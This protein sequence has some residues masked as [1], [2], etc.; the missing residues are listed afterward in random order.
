VS[1][2][3]QAGAFAVGAAASGALLVG[4]L[5]ALAARPGARTNAVVMALGAGVLL[6]SVSYDL[7]EEADSQL[8]FWQVAVML[9][10]GSAVFLIGARW[11]DRS[12]GHR[13][14]HPEGHDE[15]SQGPAIVL[16]SVLDGIPESVVLGLSI[17]QGAISWPLLAG[18]ALSNLPE[19]M[20]STAGL[21][22]SGWPVARI[23]GMWS[24][25][26]VVSG[27]AC[28]AGYTLLETT[29]GAF[30]QAF[31]AGA[32]LTMVTDTMLPGSYAVERTWTGGL[33]VAGFAFSVALSAL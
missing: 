15:D 18:V 16:G 32:L 20:A 22:T 7:V 5:I 3:E 12:G 2:V 6:G 26:V 4:A 25:V 31:A 8:P 17:L 19:G 24:A 29:G 21:R 10:A 1:N 11:I 23:V 14:K 27:V 28:A 30:A 13:R 33:V 9:F